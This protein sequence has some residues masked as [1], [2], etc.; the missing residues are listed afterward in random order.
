[1]NQMNLNQGEKASD[2]N[3][4]CESNEAIGTD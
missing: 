4:L 1:V 3:E 2:P